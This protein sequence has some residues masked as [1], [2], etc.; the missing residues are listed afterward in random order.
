MLLY[1]WLPAD[2]FV[3]R[4]HERAGRYV[5]EV[6]LVQVLRHDTLVLLHP[7]MT[8]AAP[9]LTASDEPEQT[10]EL[11]CSPMR[12]RLSR[13]GLVRFPLQVRA[14]KG[15]RPSGTRVSDSGALLPISGVSLATRD[16]SNEMRDR[17]SRI[18]SSQNPER[19]V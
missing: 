1:F 12:L 7:S 11:G 8:Q 17:T 18:T 13:S 19:R 16:P 6:L 15:S 9:H 3:D 2:V 4:L 14:K 5:L 10:G